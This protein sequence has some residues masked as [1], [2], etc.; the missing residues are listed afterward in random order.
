MEVHGVTWSRLIRELAELSPGCSS[1][2]GDTERGSRCHPLSAPFA[3]GD[4]V[5]DGGSGGEA[6]LVREPGESRS[7]ASRG[8]RRASV[9]RKIGAQQNT[10]A[11][12]GAS[13]HAR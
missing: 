13:V 3:Y 12:V 5:A 11:T 8:A 1:C 6:H 7:S 9:V 10:S 4:G 2:S